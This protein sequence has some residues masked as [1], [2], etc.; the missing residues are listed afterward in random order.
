MKHR[1]PICAK[2]TDSA[3]DADFPFCSARCRDHDLGNWA[4][5]KYVV[6]EPLFDEEDLGNALKPNDETIH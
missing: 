4:S 2:P 5:E 3:T 1:C 6:T